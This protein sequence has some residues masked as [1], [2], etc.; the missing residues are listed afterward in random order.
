MKHKY[1]LDVSF[2]ENKMREIIGEKTVFEIVNTS[3]HKF[4]RLNF[5]LV[6]RWSLLFARYFL[7]TT[8]CFLLVARYFLLVARN[9][10]LIILFF[11][12]ISLNFSLQLCS[13]CLDKLQFD[14][15]INVVILIRNYFIFIHCALSIKICRFTQN[16]L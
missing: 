2:Q 13:L 4:S 8:R 6:A 7:L 5:L 12:I 11:M 3:I 15:I 14:V 1:S 16:N 10:L 9:C